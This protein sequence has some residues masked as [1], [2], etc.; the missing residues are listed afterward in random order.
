MNYFGILHYKMIFGAL[1][2]LALLPFVRIR[3]NSFFYTILVFAGVVVA[4]ALVNKTGFVLTFWFFQNVAI[5]FLMYFVVVSYLSE[6]NIKKVYKLIMFIAAIQLPIILIQRVLY[7]V[8]TR[9][10]AVTVSDYDIGFGTFYTSDD[11]ALSFFVLGSILFLLFDDDHNYIIK[12]KNFLLIWFTLTILVLNSK[13]SYLILGLIWGYYL[14]TKVKLKIIL[15][16][17][18][19]GVLVVSLAYLFGLRDQILANVSAIEEQLAFNLKLEK[20][21]SFYLN[22]Q[23]NRTAA[24]LYLLSVPLKLLGEGPHALYN[25][26]TN[27]F[28]KGGDTGQFI[29]FYVEL[30]II[31][32]LTSYLVC[33]T[34]IR[35]LK[36][37]QFTILYFIVLCLIS[38]VSNIFLDASIMMIFVI[39][40]CSY[41]IPLKENTLT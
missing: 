19:T 1:L 18:I 25:P 2:P 15:Y 8:L 27:R 35:G 9:F 17:V 34:I 14:I 22:A 36:I 40:C 28:N 4:S 38:A 26:I 5:V 16:F 10:A 24:L 7:P 6:N 32:L 13:V 39:F 21:R 30:G 29:S 3:P 12:N 23:G 37:S 33:Y 41:L 11:I 20:A 31:G